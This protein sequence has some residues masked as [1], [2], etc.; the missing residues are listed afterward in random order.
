MVEGRMSD[1]NHYYKNVGIAEGMERSSG[2][3]HEILKKLDEV[4]E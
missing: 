1:F 4:D 3:I 2:I